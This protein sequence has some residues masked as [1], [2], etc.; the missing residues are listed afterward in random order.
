M[1]TKT[2]F[3]IF[4]AIITILVVTALATEDVNENIRFFKN[5]GS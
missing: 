5:I 4:L 2:Q 1:F 3:K